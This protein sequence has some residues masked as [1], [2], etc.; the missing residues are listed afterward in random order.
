MI[1]SNYK[2][3]DLVVSAG[4]FLESSDVGDVVSTIWGSKGVTRVTV[5]TSPLNPQL[6]TSTNIISIHF[7]VD[8][9]SFFIFEGDFL[10]S[11]QEGDGYFCYAL[12]ESAF[13]NEFELVDGGDD[14]EG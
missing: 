2:R 6:E 5:T 12:G 13:F 14:D 10:I 8:G 4:Q 7:V 3:K 1:T 9:L 11:Q